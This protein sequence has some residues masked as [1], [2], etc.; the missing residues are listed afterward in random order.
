MITNTIIVRCV[1]NL[2]LGDHMNK[3][4]SA[5]VTAAIAGILT[6]GT[7]FVP[8]SA[9]AEDVNCYGINTCKGTGACGSK[10]TGA[11][12]GGSN[13]CKGQGFIKV[14]SEECKSKGGFLTEEE[15]MAAAKNTPSKATKAGKSKAKK[16]KEAVTETVTP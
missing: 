2:K 14:S 15:A 3:R 8:S 9:K 7:A 12:C 11:S 13:A 6:A 5:L 4:N 10:A 1:Y 16:S